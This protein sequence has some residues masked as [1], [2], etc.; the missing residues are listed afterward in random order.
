MARAT[1][2]KQRPS[3]ARG[4][5]AGVISVNFEGVESGGGRPVPDG[6]YTATLTKLTQEEGQSSGEPYLHCVWKVTSGNA[7]GASIHDNISLQPQSLW[8]FR[9]LLECMGF[10]VEEADMDIDP[11]TFSAK[12]AA[13]KSPTKTMKGEIVRASPAS[14]RLVTKR[15]KR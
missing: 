1:T 13:S 8:R 14:W 15:K 9:T 12:S 3:R 6:D 4:K 11:L 7:A 2:R 5:K 10:E